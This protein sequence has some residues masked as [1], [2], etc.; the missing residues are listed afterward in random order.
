M[1]VAHQLCI[2][3]NVHMLASELVRSTHKHPEQIP[4]LALFIQY[5]VL[6]QCNFLHA[7]LTH[8]LLTNS[9]KLDFSVFPKI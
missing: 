9:V 7:I 3:V 1:Q 5:T 4:A 6:C 2:A 8:I